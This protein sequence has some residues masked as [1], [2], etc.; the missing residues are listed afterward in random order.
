MP[1]VNF[2]SDF[3]VDEHQEPFRRDLPAVDVCGVE[4]DY[5]RVRAAIEYFVG[6]VI[7]DIWLSWLWFR[8]Y[9][10]SYPLRCDRR[11]VGCHR[12][13]GDLLVIGGH[14]W[15]VA[16][17]ELPPALRDVEVTDD[18]WKLFN[19][20]VE[21]FRYILVDNKNV[22]LVRHGGPAGLGLEYTRAASYDLMQERVPGLMYA[23]SDSFWDIH[24]C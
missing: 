16:I 15:R 23:V 12:P 8:R 14:N 17:S 19:S 9:I 22:R 5:G 3:V 21:W 2:F 18:T 11:C 4:N 13:R 24:R 10:L 1:P 20:H 7:P 6:E